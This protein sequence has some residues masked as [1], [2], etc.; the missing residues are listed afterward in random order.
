[1]KAAEIFVG[2]YFHD[3]TK[4]HLHLEATGPTSAFSKQV[5]DLM[6]E[7]LRARDWDARDNLDAVSAPTL[8]IW[9]RSD[10]GHAYI[11][12]HIQEAIPH[13]EVKVIEEAGHF[14]WYE[15][16]EE[17]YQLIERFWSP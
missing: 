5:S 13:A 4:A 2:A 3:P 7:D 17:F 8:I 15:Q 9:G 12:G 11:P 6:Y 1:M 10:P 14:M 16:R